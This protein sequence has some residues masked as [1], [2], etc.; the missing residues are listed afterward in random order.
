MNTIQ[1]R[2]VSVHELNMN[3]NA[4]QMNGLFAKLFIFIRLYIIVI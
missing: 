4:I 1:A 3:V 2:D